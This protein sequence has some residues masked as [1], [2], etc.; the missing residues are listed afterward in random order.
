MI[1]GCIRGDDGD[2]DRGRLLLQL[3]LTTKPETPG[4]TVQRHCVGR[5]GGMV[6]ACHPLPT[7]CG[8]LF[9]F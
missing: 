9:E 7:S 3:P 1:G 5:A 6:T 4:A 2:R 8:I